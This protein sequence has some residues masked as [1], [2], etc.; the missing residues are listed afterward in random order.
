MKVDS[1]RDPPSETA[2]RA[3]GVVTAGRAVKV[4]AAGVAVI[5][6]VIVE[7]A[8]ATVNVTIGQD[9]IVRATID[10]GTIVRAIQRICK[11]RVVSNIAIAIADALNTVNKDNTKG[12]VTIAIVHRVR[13]AHTV[14][15]R[16]MAK[17]STVSAAIMGSVHTDKL[18]TAH[19]AATRGSVR[20]RCRLPAR[21]LAS[22]LK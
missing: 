22:A 2:N 18:T 13:T 5:G 16:A 11:L 20:R 3:L 6:I 8:I 1:K 4:A 14:K 19:A 9:R 12:N 10:Q 7:V 21:A 15:V 17:V